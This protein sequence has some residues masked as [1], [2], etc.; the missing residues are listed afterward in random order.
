MNMPL[1]PKRLK[2]MDIRNQ[3]SNPKLSIFSRRNLTMPDDSPIRIQSHQSRHDR[4]KDLDEA[5]LTQLQQA[6]AMGRTPSQNINYQQGSDI[7]VIQAS[8]IQR[9]KKEAQ[10]ERVETLKEAVRQNLITGS[11]TRAYRKIRQINPVKAEEFLDDQVGQVLVTRYGACTN[12]WTGQLCPKHN[13]CFKNCKHLHLTGSETE[14]E[15]LL[16]ELTIQEL[17]RAKVQ[18]LAYEGAY[19]AETALEALDAEI[20]GIKKAMQAWQ[21]AADQ[22]NRL[23]QLSGKLGEIKVS[24]QAFKNGESHY[25]E[26]KRPKSDEEIAS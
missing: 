24:V 26:L 20:A 25:G 21:E 16:K 10:V 9:L 17:H 18:Q 19:K 14:R 4:N 7:Q 1:L 3:L 15:E 6:L 2:Y 13:K 12:E 11:V 8:N 23:W 5:G 22:R